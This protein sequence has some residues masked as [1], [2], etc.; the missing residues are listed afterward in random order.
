MISKSARIQSLSLILGTII[1]TSL[2]FSNSVA[3]AVNLNPAVKAEITG[4]TTVRDVMFT[5]VIISS[6]NEVSINVRYVGNGTSPAMT[7][8][9]KGLSNHTASISQG[10]NG[11]NAGWTSPNTVSVKVNGPLSLY[12]AD[13]LKVEVKPSN[14]SSSTGI[15][16]STDNPENYTQT[17]GSQ[18]IVNIRGI[19]SLTEPSMVAL[20]STDDDVA[21]KKVDLDKALIQPGEE[22]SILPSKMIDVTIPMNKIAKPNS[23]VRAC[24]LQLGDNDFSQ[25]TKCTTVYAQPGNTEDNR[26]TLEIC[27]R[28]LI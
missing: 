26:S 25:R 13:T 27:S 7:F 10:T 6:D 22:N 28:I 16:P 9:A 18:Y 3:S 15:K 21:A 17:A 24:V 19:S 23:E 4:T 5:W 1:L 20:I 12:D 8:L 11:T 2:L 14:T